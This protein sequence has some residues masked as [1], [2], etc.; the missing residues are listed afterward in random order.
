M[1]L[2]SGVNHTETPLREEQPTI[3]GLEV[4]FD[5]RAALD[6]IEDQEKRA[7][8]AERVYKSA[9]DRAKELRKIADAENE[10]L[11][12]LIREFGQRREA[13]ALEAQGPAE[14][15]IDPDAV[16]EPA[17]DDDTDEPDDEDSDEPDDDDEHEVDL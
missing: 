6:A 13:L 12:K 17:D 4:P 9:A 5:T 8:Q 14:P 7:S 1:D 11:R 2:D 3:P 16:D 15:E 10:A